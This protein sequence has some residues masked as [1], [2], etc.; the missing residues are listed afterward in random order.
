VFPRVWWK[1]GRAPQSHLYDAKPNCSG[2]TAGTP[3]MTVWDCVTPNLITPAAIQA[4]GT[5]L[6]LSLRVKSSYSN[7]EGNRPVGSPARDDL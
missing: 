5:D 1:G 6:H 7:T 4:L 2:G 3:E